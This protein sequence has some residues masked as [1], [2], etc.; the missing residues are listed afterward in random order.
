MHFG[1]MMNFS[2]NIIHETFKE[3]PPL[4]RLAM[5]RMPRILIMAMIEIYLFATASRPAVEH[6]QPPTHWYQ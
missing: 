3:R 6:T 1:I 5:G 2:M 4:P